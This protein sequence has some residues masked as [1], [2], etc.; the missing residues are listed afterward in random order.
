MI[1][2]FTD[3]ND[4]EK[5]IIEDILSD[6]HIGYK[7]ITNYIDAEITADDKEYDDIYIVSYDIKINT[8]LEMFD[9][10]KWLVDK[11]IIQVVKLN[12]CYRKREKRHK[13]SKD[14]NE[15]DISE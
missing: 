15:I 1:F 9:Y 8:S 6:N 7:V 5:R 2:Y 10:L 12:K 13:V 14:K 3:K 4:F 11:R